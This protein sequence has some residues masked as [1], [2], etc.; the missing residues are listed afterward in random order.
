MLQPVWDGNGRSA[1]G[2][3]VQETGRL[4]G[5]GTEK[6]GQN[7]EGPKGLAEHD[8]GPTGEAAQEQGWG[9][10]EEQ[11]TSHP[12]SKPPHYGGTD[13]DYGARDFGDTPEEPP[14]PNPS[15]GQK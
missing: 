10:N 8:L 2:H 9:L 13:Y 4:I 12:A 15:S 5:M 7:T 14:Q 1:H 6:P 3:L 11:R